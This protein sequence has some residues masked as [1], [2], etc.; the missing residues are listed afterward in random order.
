MYASHVDHP[1]DLESS[2]ISN[3]LY[4]SIPSYVLSDHVSHICSRQEPQDNHSSAIETHR[5][6]AAPAES[7]RRFPASCQS[8]F[9]PSSAILCTNT[10][11]LLGP[12]SLLRQGTGP[13]PGFPPV[14]DH[15]RR[16]W[17]R[18]LGPHQ[19]LC[20]SWSLVLVALTPTTWVA[21]TLS[22]FYSTILCGRLCFNSYCRLCLHK[23]SLDHAP[24]HGKM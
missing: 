21:L 12:H 10:L 15:D 23:A 17:E 9:H 5:C 14:R 8:T 13:H 3:V 19:L 7:V 24:V 16:R 4:T 1:D 11:P 6:P 22:M 20:R 18:V 2:G